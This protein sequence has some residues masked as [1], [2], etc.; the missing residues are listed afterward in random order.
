MARRTRGRIS[1]FRPTKKLYVIATEGTKTEPIYFEQFTPSREKSIRIKILPPIKHKSNP[2]AV[3]K[4]LHAYVREHDLEQKDELWLVIDRDKWDRD[5]LDSIATNCVRMG[6]HIAVSNPCFELWLYIHLADPKHFRDAAHCTSELA[7]IMGGYD[8][9]NYDISILCDGI[10]HA[11][12]RAKSLDRDETHTWPR[13]TGTR[14][15]KLVI[16]LL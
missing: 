8:K 12:E 16:N 10:P 11:I 2:K 7:R 4:R 13:N 6:Y 15:Y 5:L 3:F 14:V 1:G 9:S